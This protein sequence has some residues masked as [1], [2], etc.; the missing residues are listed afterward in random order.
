MQ[1]FRDSEQSFAEA[2][3]QVLGVSVDSWAAQEAFRKD[4]GTS[5]PLLG[6]WPKNEVGAAYGVYQPD[7][8]T[9]KRVTFVLDKDHVVRHIVDDPREFERHA[10]EALEAVQR[11]AADA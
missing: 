4:L 1:A 8:F 2:G 10:R 7:R 3:A 6:D 9:H 11:L 5:I